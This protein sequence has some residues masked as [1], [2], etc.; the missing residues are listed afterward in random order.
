MW[1]DNNSASPYYGRMYISFNN[2]ASGGALQVIHSDDGVN[3]TSPVTLYS[4]FRRDVQLT[5][6]PGSDGKVFVAALDEN[7][8][9]VGNTGQHNYMYRSVDGGATWT[10]S[11]MGASFKIPGNTTCAGS[12]YFPV[13]PPIW[14]QTGY[15]QPAVGPNG[16][17]HYAYAAY[18]TTNSS[19][20]ADIMYVRS[21]DDGLTWSTPIRLNTDTGTKPQ[22]MPS[23]RATS[24]GGVEV[25]WY[26]Q[27]NDTSGNR[28]YQRY[29][30]FSTDN[31]LTWGP[32]EP[33]TKLLPPPAQPDP[34]IKACWAGDYNY[35]SANNVSGFDTWTDSREKL[36][37]VWTQEVFYREAII[38]P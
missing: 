10:V 28:S 25:T 14:S 19:D 22:W 8:G 12:S 37:G 21:T 36:S 16:V 18:S 31:G 13:I 32:N 26:D 20:V 6:S 5:G 17:V 35:G 2:N 34:T 33:V 9:G 29:A 15:G 24:F 1:V 11:S 7:G 30:R 3:W 38:R 23:V 27:R 4:L